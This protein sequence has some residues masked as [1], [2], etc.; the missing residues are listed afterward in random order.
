MFCICMFAW[1][2]VPMCQTLVLKPA[3]LNSINC[4][5]FQKKKSSC[6]KTYLPDAALINA[7]TSKKSLKHNSMSR[8]Y[9][10]SKSFILHSS[11]F[12]QNTDIG[13]NT[14]IIKIMWKL[15]E[16]NWICK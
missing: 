11:D 5:C 13:W 4:R 6:H 7:D 2:R 1:V 14:L 15:V 9:K 10:P 16:E 12:R 8:L 3:C